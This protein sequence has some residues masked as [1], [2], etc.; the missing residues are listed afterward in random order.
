MMK[1]EIDIDG[2]DVPDIVTEVDLTVLKKLILIKILSF[3]GLGCLAL[4][5]FSI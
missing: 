3:T 4:G 5:A 2:D 1:I